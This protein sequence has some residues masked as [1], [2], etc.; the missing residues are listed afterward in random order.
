MKIAIGCDHGAFELKNAIADHLRTKGFEVDDKG[1]F[2]K[3]SCDYPVFAKAVAHDV[4]D[5]KCDFGVLCCTS[6]IGMSIVA[7]KVRNARAA[8]VHEPS[9]AEM[10]RRHNNANIICFGAKLVSPEDACR[11]VD[12]FLA[13]PFDGGRHQRRVDMFE[14]E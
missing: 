1:T 10:S 8:L 11:Y 14:E 12:I 4:A 13:T 2:S 9:G 5:G 3:E 7:N 6:G